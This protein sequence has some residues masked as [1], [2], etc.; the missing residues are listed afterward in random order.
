M[1]NLD[2]TTSLFSSVGK[3]FITLTVTPLILSVPASSAWYCPLSKLFRLML[4]VP[5]GT[6][7]TPFSFFILI[8]PGFLKYTLTCAAGTFIKLTL[9]FISP[10]AV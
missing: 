2:N 1:Y 4:T 9:V 10:V 8:L 3:S 7:E 6:S 5:L